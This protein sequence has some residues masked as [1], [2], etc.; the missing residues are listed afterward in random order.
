MLHIKLKLRIKLSF[1]FECRGIGIS[2]MTLFDTND[3]KIRFT[4]EKYFSG[5][6]FPS[7][8]K[9]SFLNKEGRSKLGC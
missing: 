1:T 5:V 9:I 7:V 2:K 3:K 8:S 6:F 4:I